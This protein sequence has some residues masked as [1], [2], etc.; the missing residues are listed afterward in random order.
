MTPT[1]KKATLP[2]SRIYTAALDPP[3]VM[4][5]DVLAA[6]QTPEG[7]YSTIL[8]FTSSGPVIRFKCNKGHPPCTATCNPTPTL[9]VSCRSQYNPH[10]HLSYDMVPTMFTVIQPNTAL[11]Y[12]PESIHGV[13][14]PASIAIT[15]AVSVALSFRVIPFMTTYSLDGTVRGSR[16]RPNI[17]GHRLC[18][19]L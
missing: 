16:F 6:Q 1:N 3:N 5:F 8:K 15:T 11:S 4:T 12:G 7:M 13:P 19:P 9:P 18:S 14:V 2:P 17:S 10:Q